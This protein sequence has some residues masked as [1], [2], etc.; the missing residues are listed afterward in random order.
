MRQA[1][2]ACL[3]RIMWT[4]LGRGVPQT[5]IILIFLELGAVRMTLMLTKRAGGEILE[6]NIWITLAVGGINCFFI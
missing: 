2:G 1:H 5:I 3:M 4:T 6:S